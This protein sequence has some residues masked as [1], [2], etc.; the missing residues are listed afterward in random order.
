MTGAKESTQ[1]PEQTAGRISK[2]CNRC[3]QTKVRCDGETPCSTCTKHSVECTYEI[4]LRRRGPGKAKDHVRALEARL[5][6]VTQKEPSPSLLGF[7]QEADTRSLGIT[8]RTRGL[9]EP[10]AIAV[11]TETG[12]YVDGSSR[13]VNPSNTARH[14][15]H[16]DRETTEHKSGPQF[17]LPLVSTD[18]IITF[19]EPVFDDMSTGYPLLSWQLFVD[20]LLSIDP[21]KNVA[22]RV[23]LDSIIAIGILFSSDNLDFKSAADAA[24]EK[25]NNAYTQLPRIMALDPDIL[26]IEALLAMAVFMKMIAD[27]RTAA[28]LVSSAVRMYEI[29]GMQSGPKS[30]VAL[31]TGDD[32]RRR[33]FWTAYILD[34]AISTQTGLLRAIDDSEYG[35]VPLRDQISSHMQGLSLHLQM[36]AEI[37]IISSVIYKRQYQRRAFAQ[38]KSELIPSLMEEHW[39]LAYWLRTVPEDL[40]P[41]IDCLELQPSPSQETLLLHLKYYHCVDM[42]H[43]AARRQSSRTGA[44]NPTPSKQ[45]DEARVIMSIDTSRYAAL[46]TL[47]AAAAFPRRPFVNLWNIL[48]YPVSACISLLTWVLEDPVSVSARSDALALRSFRRFLEDA[49]EDDG[50]DLRRVLQVVAQIERQALDA[51]DK[52]SATHTSTYVNAEVRERMGQVIGGTLLSSQAQKLKDVLASCAHPMYI[53]QALMSNMRTHDSTTADALMEALGL[54]ERGCERSGWLVPDSL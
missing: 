31:D 34:S 8:A 46:V 38:T 9:N 18:D 6:D 41:N 15:T 26:T 45:L 39:G 44:A 1:Q 10:Y 23:Q 25:F 4:H 48:C 29:D 20:N 33:A 7:A 47:C 35:V 40:R 27:V 32:R 51:A 13:P 42:V 17:L 52:A 54:G 43:W 19:L 5:R 49:I 16:G 22:W 30:R 36:I 24:R 12:G 53:A 14:R 11:N 3:R 50:C 2:A 28:Q 21:S 37:S